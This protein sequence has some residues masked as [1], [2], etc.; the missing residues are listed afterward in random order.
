MSVRYEMVRLHPRLL[1]AVAPALGLA[2]IAAVVHGGG[3]RHSLEVCCYVVGALAFVMAAVG[4]SPG[5]GYALDV[6]SGMAGSSKRDTILGAPDAP[7]GN[8]LTP[9]VPALVVAV[10]LILLGLA[11]S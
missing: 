1:I 5:R 4:N 7:P 6:E 9:A 10:L 8:T 3:F 2:V 11:L